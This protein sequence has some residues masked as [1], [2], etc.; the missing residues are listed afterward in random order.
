[1][2]KYLLV[3]TLI[4]LSF[5]TVAQSP[6]TRT[7]GVNT[8]VDNRLNAL[9]N[10]VPPM[11]E[12][13]TAANL[14]IGLD[15]C[16]AIINTRSPRRTWY[17]DCTS[18]K[19]WKQYAFYNDLIGLGSVTNVSHTN[20]LGISASIANP[21]TTPNITIAVDTSDVSILSRQ[22]AAATY[23]TILTNPITGSLTTNTIP[24]ATGANTLGNSSIYDDGTNVG[25]N[26]TSSFAA[27]FD[28]LGSGTAA[29]T[30]AARFVGGTSAAAGGLSIGSYSA[31][32][33]GLW[34]NNVT[35]STTNYAV[36]STGASTVVNSTSNLDFAISDASKWRVNSLGNFVAT[37]D[38][39]NDFGASGATRVRNI[40][41]A[42]TLTIGT[43]SV[44][45]TLTNTG[46]GRLMI[47]GSLQ[48]IGTTSSHPAIKRYSTTSQLVVRTADDAG[49]AGIRASEMVVTGGASGSLY[50][51]DGS[52]SYS[53][54]YGASF[55]DGIIKMTNNGNTDFD[56]LA[57]GGLTS[58]F[59]AI[60]RNGTGIDIKLADNS[61]YTNITSATHSLLGTSTN[62]SDLSITNS[63]LTTGSA[64]S[65]ALTGT[66][67]A[68][69]TKTGLTIT[70]SGANATASQTVTGQTISVTNTG[71][72]NTNNGLTITA[73]GAT[74]NNAIN[75]LGGQILT[76]SGS[77]SVPSLAIGNANSGVYSTAANR[78]GIA[79]GGA[80]AAEFNGNTLTLGQWGSSQTINAASGGAGNSNRAGI[81]L[82][83]G[84]GQSTGSGVAGKTTFRYTPAGSSGTSVNAYAT[85]LEIGTDGNTTVS[86]K[87]INLSTVRLKSYTVATLPAGTQGDIAYVTDALAPT[88][89]GVLVGGGAIVTIAF[90]DGTNWT[91]H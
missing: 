81:D 29:A 62:G 52:G 87:L 64:A 22:R 49:D 56:R 16:G 88:F 68:S 45:S 90:Y 41:A 2:K 12:D 43:S 36:V 65:I 14:K 27:K 38:N 84:S 47:D 67:A 35:P 69:N 1:M 77:V 30:M 50:F 4:L 39:A 19:I 13:T 54:I 80:L 79:S 89:A 51:N 26:K 85:A 76:T 34:S 9:W 59:P 3:I 48:F 37:T 15:S 71:T 83:I 58:A 73:S 28:V 31:T 6:F 63:T 53:R 66:A 78:V 10:F 72:T 24:K 8:I 32:Y 7:T 91:A 21:T 74:T 11:F 33:G 82:I 61:A 55:G 23:Q 40:Y 86:N 46:N 44:P 60:K 70:S 20:G 57:F 25:I 5:I 18:G 17:R 42:G 75:I